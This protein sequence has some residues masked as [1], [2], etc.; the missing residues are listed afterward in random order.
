MTAVAPSRCAVYD[1]GSKTSP[2]CHDTLSDQSGGL[3]EDDT[4]AQC[5]VP[6]RDMDVT[7]QPRWAAALQM[8]VPD[9]AMLALNCHVSW[10]WG[11]C[12][13]RNPLPPH[14]TSF[15]FAADVMTCGV[16]GAIERCGKCL[17]MELWWS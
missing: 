12:V 11:Q 1:C 10:D 14:T 5:G 8:R 3:G 7:D 2:F 17:E 15:F 4:L 9:H 16:V 13:P 6:E